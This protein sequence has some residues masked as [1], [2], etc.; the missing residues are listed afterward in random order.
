M[1]TMLNTLISIKQK[2]SKRVGRGISAGGGKTA[3]RGTKGQK[4]RS[5]YN[6]PKRFEGGQSSLLQRLPK[7]HGTKSR[8]N[9]PIA[10]S[11]RTLEEIFHNDQLITKDILFEKKLINNKR[12]IIKIIG[13]KIITKHFTFDQDILLSQNLK[14]TLK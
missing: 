8:I 1:M 9:K 13:A 11:Y 4:S 2:T 14:N 5:G 7:M 12:K 6:L 3:G 10:V